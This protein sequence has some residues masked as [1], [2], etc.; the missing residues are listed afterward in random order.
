M[1]GMFVS[2]TYSAYEADPILEPP[3]GAEALHARATSGTV[4]PDPRW[5]SPRPPSSYECARC[6]WYPA[7]RI[8][9]ASFTSLLFSAGVRRKVQAL[10]RPCAVRRHLG[11]QA[12]TYLFGFFGVGIVVAPFFLARNGINRLLLL[13]LPKPWFRAPEVVTRHTQPAS[14]A[15][16]LPVRL[17]CWLGPLVAVGAV[18]YVV[19][20]LSGQL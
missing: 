17:L 19:A 1:F 4:P 3:G 10:C 2:S 9:V 16:T 18:A 11:A 8:R 6:G 15:G 12:R 20:L 14:F 13:Q 5:S 7:R